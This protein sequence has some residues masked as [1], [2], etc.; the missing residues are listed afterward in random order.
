MLKYGLKLW[1]TNDY[2]IDEAVKLYEQ[3]V[4]NYIE[5]YTVPDSYSDYISKWQVLE[6]PFIIHAPHSGHGLN[7]AKREFS[8]INKKMAAG[9]Q[10]FADSLKS[11]TII[12]HPGVAGDIKETARQL[13]SINDSRAVIENKPY[14]SI[15]DNSVCNG[16]SYKDINTIIESTG[17]GFCLDIGHAICAA[18]TMNM[19]PNTLL[20]S[21]N[22]LT[23]LL[24]HLSDG[25]YISTVDQHLNIGRGNYNFNIIFSLFKE[26]EMITVETSK[27]SKMDL[28]DFLNDINYLKKIES[29]L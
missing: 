18:N 21:L 22:S 20:N 29:E 7:L 25:D 4:Y 1:S 3:G 13:K 24:Y 9:A 2:Y 8:E 6:I 15:Y 16:Y 12:F 23:P 11:E 26:S 27:S 19:D 5:L 14:Y 28:Y 17:V 10:R